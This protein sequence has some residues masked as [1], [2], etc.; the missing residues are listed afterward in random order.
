MTTDPKLNEIKTIRNRL[1]DLTKMPLTSLRGSRHVQDEIA[2]WLMQN[3]DHLLTLALAHAEAEQCPRCQ[4]HGRW[5]EIT[6]CD[7][8]EWHWCPDCSRTGKRRT[9]PA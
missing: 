6:D 4:G 5:Y 3:A 7:S 8:G 2:D 1:D 9:V